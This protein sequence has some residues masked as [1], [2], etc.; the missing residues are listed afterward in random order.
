MSR[1]ERLYSPPEIG[2][3][4]KREG[5]GRRRDLLLA[6]LFVLVMGALALGALA[7]VGPGLFGGAYTLRAYFAA[8][9]GLDPGIPVTQEGYAIGTVVSV[10]PV[11]AGR[12]GDADQ[13]PKE[14]GAR[15]A[16]DL[17]CFRAT[18]RVLDQ[19]P[20]PDDSFA[21]LGSGGLLQGQVI[22]ITPGVSPRR[23]GDDAVITTLGSEKD[24]MAQLGTLTDTLQ[25]LVDETIAP[26]LANIEAQIKTIGALLGTGADGEGV[27]AENRE[28]MASV[29]QN[30]QQVSADIEKIVDPEQ[31]GAILASVQE[32]AD[33]MA[34]VS[35]TFTERSADISKTVQHYGALAGDIRKLID[36]NEP[37]IEGSLDDL[38]YL[39]QELSATLAPILANIESASR[40]LSALSRELRN[41]P[42]SL[43]RGREVEEQAPWFQR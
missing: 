5:R 25:S 34:Q 39:L 43:L 29:F 10:E 2:A 37:A 26:A 12:D 35:A 14:D 36:K 3:P 17:P 19:W 38:Q 16:P 22:K 24:L 6:G 30:L 33:N 15:R 27:G 13:C 4:G 31:I 8:A 7:L 42:A 20:V 9:N 18:L 1:L 23:Y 40:N 28:R 41:N 11:F 21:Q 32:L